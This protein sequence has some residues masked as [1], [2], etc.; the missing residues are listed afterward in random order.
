MSRIRSD[1]ELVAALKKKLARWGR[2]ETLFRLHDDEDGRWRTVKATFSADV[3]KWLK[4]KYGKRLAIIAN[5]DFS[6]ASRS[7]GA[8]IVVDNRVKADKANPKPAAKLTLEV[9]D[10]VRRNKAGEGWGTLAAEAGLKR[11]TLIQRV[12]AA[13]KLKLFGE[14]PA[15]AARCKTVV[16]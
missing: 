10:L 1:D 11:S 8:Q 12:K 3:K 15:T 7:P 6:A 16:A 4:S 5:E 2:C 14:L 9:G 13:L